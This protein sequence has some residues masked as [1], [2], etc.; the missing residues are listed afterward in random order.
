MTLTIKSVT[1]HQSSLCPRCFRRSCDR[2]PEETK[3]LSL[4]LQFIPNRETPAPPHDLKTSNFMTLLCPAWNHIW[5]H[6]NIYSRKSKKSQ[7]PHEKTFVLHQREE[8]M[9][10]R[11][12]STSLSEEKIFWFQQQNVTE[13]SQWHSVLQPFWKMLLLVRSRSLRHLMIRC[14]PLME[15]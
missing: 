11:G 4:D 9:R 15:L 14:V 2:K 6:K 3:H 1:N 7:N 10:K 13:Q 8:K 5:K 12:F